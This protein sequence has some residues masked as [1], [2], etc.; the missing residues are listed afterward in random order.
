VFE[1]A[2]GD[3]LAGASCELAI[4]RSSD[5]AFLGTEL[6]W[7]TTPYW[8]VCYR[9]EGSQR[10]LRL[11]A[12]S[13]IVDGV[14]TSSVHALR[15]LIRAGRVREQGILRIRQLVGS[16][17]R[18][19]GRTTEPVQAS[20]TMGDPIIAS[21]GP[22]PAST[23]E[24]DSRRHRMAAGFLL[25]LLLLVAVA[26]GAWLFGWLDPLIVPE[27]PL[28]ATTADPP[29]PPGEPST[30]QRTSTVAEPERHDPVK[31]AGARVEVTETAPAPPNGLSGRQFVQHYL[32]Q[33]PSAEELYA[34]ARD[35]E[36]EGDC[37]AAILLYT[38]GAAADPGIAAE[39]AHLYDP[40][41]FEPSPCIESPN[42]ENAL[43][44]YQDAARAGVLRAQ[45]RLGA[46]L[47]EQ[48]GSGVTREQGV[49]WLR[50]AGAAGDADAQRIL[51]EIE[52]R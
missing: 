29:A 12:G 5:D 46:L 27:G 16:P 22:P 40:G 2:G 34:R 18:A 26:G 20:P 50:R 4:Q 49:E 19:G 13:E 10:D 25:L 1:I 44:W 6:H 17:A 41:G 28:E 32:G 52:R 7:Q 31:P 48:A 38:R 30:G 21:E 11:S 51:G 43:V 3:H 37:E 39:V 42:R 33:A 8:H 24:P 36:Q 14:I 45:S 15:V 47:V 9:I 35:R 23:D